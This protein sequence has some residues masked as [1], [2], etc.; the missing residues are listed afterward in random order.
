MFHVDQQF[1][2]RL[3]INSYLFLPGINQLMVYRVERDVLLYGSFNF[4]L[5]ASEKDKASSK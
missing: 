2:F 3:C 1:Y 5:V 4:S